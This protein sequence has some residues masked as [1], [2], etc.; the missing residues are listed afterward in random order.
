MGFSL[1]VLAAGIALPSPGVVRGHVL[2]RFVD[3]GAKEL[4]GARHERAL[5]GGIHLFHAA[6]D[7]ESAL[8]NSLA[9]DPRVA[10]AEPERIRQRSSTVVANDPLF[11]AQWALRLARIPDAWARTRGSPSVVVAVLDTGI[12]PHPDLAGRYLPGWDF[13]SS[14]ES[15]GDGD[16]RDP[17]PTDAG[18]A[19]PTSSGYHGTHVAGIIAAHADNH[20]GIAGVDWNC[21]LLVVRVLGVDAG[22]G[23]DGDIADAIRW[24][25]GLP[26]D[27]VPDNA[28]PAAVINLSFGG[29]G[30]SRTLQSAVDAAT[31]R[32]AIVVAAAGNGGGDLTDYAPADLVHVIAVGAADRSGQLAAYSNRGPRVDLLAPGGD[33]AAGDGVVS[34]MR[35]PGSGYTYA[36]WAGT[37]QATPHVAG[38]AALMRALDPGLGVERARMI[39]H[40]TAAA[41]AGCDGACG[42]GLLDG[43]AALAAVAGECGGGA[44]D[45]A[46]PPAEPAAT[47][48][49][50][51]GARPAPLCV[52]ALLPGVALL[53]LGR[54]RRRSARF[55]RSLLVRVVVNDESD[56]PRSGSRS[57]FASL[58]PSIPRPFSV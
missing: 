36:Y 28:T 24:A 10:W 44:C 14:P 39:L 38:V 29:S 17:D 47:G 54:R 12:L 40:D 35:T 50:T 8:I 30:D 32:G 3:G 51:S 16:G 20:L 15:A 57:A 1:A 6:D 23:T 58:P 37:S 53:L 34:T 21:P 43:E 52:V 55:A 33:F 11:G 41:V 48:C 9:R 27:G 7:N 19:D 49:S 5:A 18:T 13:I 2:V 42:G 26:V 56:R 4:R 45:Q 25:A 22:K 31:D 46:S